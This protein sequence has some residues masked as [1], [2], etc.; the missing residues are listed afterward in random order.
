MRT[1]L[2]ANTPHAEPF[3]YTLIIPLQ[4]LHRAGLNTSS[5]FAVPANKRVSRHLPEPVD[6]VVVRMVI[7]AAFNDALGAAAAYIQI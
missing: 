5:V 3:Q 7:V 2:A 6:A 1:R 4:R